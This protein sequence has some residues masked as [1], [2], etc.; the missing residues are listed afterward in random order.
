MTHEE[1]KLSVT[2]TA[3]PNGEVKLHEGNRMDKPK[4]LPSN[5]PIV[6]AMRYKRAE[7]EYRGQKELLKEAKRIIN[8][9][10]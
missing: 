8:S 7:N 9:K 4:I 6:I 2:S 3:Y 10:K 1:P 5:H